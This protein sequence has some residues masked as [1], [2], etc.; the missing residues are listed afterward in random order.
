M[1]REESPKMKPELIQQIAITWEL[2]GGT[3]SEGAKDHLVNRLENYDPVK[4]SRALSRCEDECRG[5]ITIANVIS[6]IDDGHLG[7][8]EAWALMPHGEDDT[9]VWTTPMMEAYSISKDL[10]PDKV[11][12]RMA[13]KEAYNRGVQRMKEV[14]GPNDKPIWWIS[15]GHNEAQRGRIVKDAFHRGRISINYVERFLPEIACEISGALPANETKQLESG[16]PTKAEL[17]SL[18]GQLSGKLG[19]K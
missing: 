16:A 18:V 10:L 12:A 2:C 11:A 9:V 8:D 13:F 17:S 14:T 19:E 4:V 6:R 3:L 1:E 5:R 15:A 7:A